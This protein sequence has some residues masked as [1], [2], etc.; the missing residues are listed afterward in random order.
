[1][2]ALICTGITSL[3]GYIADE[4][5]NF[6][7]SAPDEDVHAFVNRIERPIGT[8]LV[9][10]RLYE[11]MSVWETMPTEGEPGVVAD[12]AEIWRAAE[13]IIFS[14]TLGMASTT[15]TRIERQ[16]DP[17]MIRRLKASSSRDISIGGPNLAAHA[18]EAGLVDRVRQF[19]SPVIVGGG[20]RFLPDGVAVHLDLVDEFRF[21]NGVI[22]LD[23]R[24][25]GPR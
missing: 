1:M 7:W 16:F 6:D 21:A 9:G 2:A 19:L 4:T 5:G 18:F 25:Q 22:Y 3:D 23:Y 15:R 11:V 14:T 10:R 13:K 17:A 12:Y 20:T 8:Y 24:V